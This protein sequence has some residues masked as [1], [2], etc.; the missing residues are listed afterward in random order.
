MLP[1]K[2]ERGLLSGDAAGV[3]APLNEAV[4][5]ICPK[6]DLVMMSDEPSC[7]A[8]AA[9]IAKSDGTKEDE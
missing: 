4:E 5:L 7:E 6:G 1:R 3:C 2:I 8:C 9:V